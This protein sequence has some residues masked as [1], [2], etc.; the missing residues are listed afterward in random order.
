MGSLVTFQS[1]S[2]L[3]KIGASGLSLQCAHNLEAWPAAQTPGGPSGPRARP[4]QGGRP[5][6]G[7]EPLL[8]GPSRE[9]RPP[10]PTRPF[11]PGP[12]RPRPRPTHRGRWW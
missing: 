11:P 6:P 9:G 10:P 7:G 4:S 12:A 1:T 3:T 2:R 5:S 8:G